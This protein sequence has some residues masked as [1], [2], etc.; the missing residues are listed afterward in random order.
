M[1]VIECFAC[2]NCQFMFVLTTAIK[3]EL[4]IISNV[5]D[6][7]QCF[8][9]SRVTSSKECFINLFGETGFTDMYFKVASFH[10]GTPRLA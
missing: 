6:G 2:D 9:E 3:L 8:G 7:V 10:L 1:I 5:G 4:E